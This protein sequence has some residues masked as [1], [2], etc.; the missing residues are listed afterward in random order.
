MIMPDYAAYMICTS[1]RSGSTLLCKLL[2]ATGVAGHPESWFYSPSVTDW[3]E[4]LGV[5]PQPDA[6]E[7]EVLDAVFRA[8]MEKGSAGKGP[9][10]LRQ[11]GESFPYLLEK[12]AVLFPDG[13]SGGGRFHRMFGRT[14]FIHLTRSDKV[15]QAVSYLKAEQSGLW[16]VAPDGS[17]LERVA[18]HRDPTYDQERLRAI[19]AMLEDYDRVWND[20][21]TSEQIAPFRIPYDDLA[22]D[23]VG[24]LR[25]TLEALGLDPAAATGVRPG[26]RKLA[27]SSSTDW[28]R[29]FRAGQGLE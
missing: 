10:G 22:A 16:H 19:V 28:V 14:L 24:T 2:A 5:W 8:A 12:L 20:W 25:H 1:P 4:E 23:P 15:E 9:F 11:Q 29:R 3:L 7:L 18:P 27:D 26:V 13:T 17:E 6:S 21:F